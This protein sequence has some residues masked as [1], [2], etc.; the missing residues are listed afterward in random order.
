MTRGSQVSPPSYFLDTPLALVLK[1]FLQ[2]PHPN[3]PHSTPLVSSPLPTLFLFSPPPL[4]ITTSPTPGSC[5]LNQAA[6]LLVPLPHSGQQVSNAEA[7]WAQWG[8]VSV[9]WH[10]GLITHVPPGEVVRAAAQHLIPA[11][12]VPGAGEPPPDLVPFTPECL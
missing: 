11:S 9:Q 10:R 3:L 7:P 1:R 6:S 8:H 5:I 2:K 4:N 12:L